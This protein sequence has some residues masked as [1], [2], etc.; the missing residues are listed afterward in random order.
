[1][2]VANPKPNLYQQICETRKLIKDRFKKYHEALVAR[3]STLFTRRRRH[4]NKPIDIEVFQFLE[5]MY[6]L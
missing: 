5:K 3:E 1:M 6:I 4:A 2:T